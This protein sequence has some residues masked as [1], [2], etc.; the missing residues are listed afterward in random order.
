MSNEN[1][2]N[3]NNALSNDIG[4]NRLHAEEFPDNLG[5]TEA[6]NNTEGCST[7]NISSSWR[8]RSHLPKSNK[9]YSNH[10]YW[11]KRFTE[12]DEYEWLVTYNDIKTQISR[13]LQKESKILLVGCGNSSF[14]SDLFD[15]GYECITSL[16]FSKNVIAAMKSK[17]EKTRPSMEWIVMDMTDMST[18]PCNHYDVVID[19][20]AMDAFMTAEGDVWNPD[21]KVIDSSRKMCRHISRILKIGGFHLQISFSQPHFRKKYLLGEHPLGDN[22]DQVEEKIISQQDL[23]EYSVEF[24][25]DYTVETLDDNEGEGCFHHFL[26]IMKK[27][28]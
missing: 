20:A 17:N 8:T 1:E 12:E 13:F 28:L 10:E 9:E 11:E 15:A 27:K 6:I 25:W 5:S 7:I 3:D 22:M 23:V 2:D 19:K 4:K 16:D 26:F 14:S 21:Q 18:L 24:G